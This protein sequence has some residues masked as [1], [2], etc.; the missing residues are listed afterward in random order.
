M[1]RRASGSFGKRMKG[2]WS[3]CGKR[4]KR[5]KRKKRPNWISGSTRSK[6]YIRIFGQGEI[7]PAGRSF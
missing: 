2:R 4:R 1:I 3:F 6:R 7:R 5:K